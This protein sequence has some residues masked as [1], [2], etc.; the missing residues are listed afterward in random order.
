ML[1][2][3]KQYLFVFIPINEKY[4]YNKNVINTILK[5]EYIFYNIGKHVYF[6]L[7]LSLYTLM[8]L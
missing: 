2:E 6:Y 1:K 5:M 4:K 8:W 3:T 7:G